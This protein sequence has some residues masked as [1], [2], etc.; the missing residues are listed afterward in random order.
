[1]S[2]NTLLFIY[3]NILLKMLFNIISLL[4][5]HIWSSNTPFARV[6]NCSYPDFRK[7]PMVLMVFPLQ[8]VCMASDPRLSR[9][10]NVNSS[11]MNVALDNLNRQ[12]NYTIGVAAMTVVGTGPVSQM[13]PIN[14]KR[15]SSTRPWR[16]LGNSLVYPPARGLLD[17]SH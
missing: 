3:S 14:A 13:W 7:L 2:T 1:M 6:Q 11:V 4:S 16:F 15:E 5:G 12:T 17:C 8:I 10:F 9:N